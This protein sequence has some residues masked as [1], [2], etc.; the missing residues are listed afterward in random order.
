[1]SVPLDA[2][3]FLRRECPTCEREFKW[4]PSQ[5]ETETPTPDA[6]GYFCPYCGAQAKQGWHTKA[7]VELARATVVQEVVDPM[8]DDFTRKLQSSSSGIVKVTASHKP[9]Q[10]P[11]KLSEPDD[12]LRIDFPCHPTEPIKVLNDW[13]G[14]LHCL[15]C[16]TTVS[17]D[18]VDEMP[19][20]GELS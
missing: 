4:L 15:I 17:G 6:A 12:M 16:G 13:T 9:S 8:L 11:P 5:G 2:D 10:Q 20:S 18:S 19:G 1:M 3:G 14:P 7:Q